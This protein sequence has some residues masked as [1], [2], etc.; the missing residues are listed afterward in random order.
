[1]AVLYWA[2]PVVVPLVLAVLFTFVLTPVVSTLQRSLG[3][4][5]A[6]FAV[7]LVTFSALGV[8][9]WA[10]TRQITAVVQELPG[11]RNNIRHKIRDIR[12]FGQSGPVETLK[13]TVAEIQDELE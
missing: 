13:E 3:R 5:L 10:V 6:V 12:A 11:Y 4:L 8:T 7:V 2:Q 9:G 1:C